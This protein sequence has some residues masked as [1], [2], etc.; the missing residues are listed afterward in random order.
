MVM[1]MSVLSLQKLPLVLSRFKIWCLQRP[2]RMIHNMFTFNLWPVFLWHLTSDSV[3]QMGSKEQPSA[4]WRLH[5]DCVNVSPVHVNARLF[6]VVMFL[7][8]YLVSLMIYSLV[9]I[10]IQQPAWAPHI[11][12]DI[13][14]SYFL[15]SH[16]M[17]LNLMSFHKQL[18]VD[19]VQIVSLSS[20]VHFAQS[21]IHFFHFQRTK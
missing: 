8:Q 5:D 3:P 17:T 6:S 2:P 11:L 7:L 21:H 12:M 9:N 10:H 19:T 4:L 18:I 16:M 14:V 15:Q 1:M 20:L 13:F